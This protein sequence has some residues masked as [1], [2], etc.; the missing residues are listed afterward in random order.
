MIGLKRTKR[1][2][3][4]LVIDTYTDVDS[5][6]DIQDGFFDCIMI[7][8]KNERSLANILNGASPILSYKCSYKPVFATVIDDKDRAI[9]S[10]IDLYTNNYDT[11]KV[12][13][14][15]DKIKRATRK[16]HIKREIERPKSPNQLFSNICRYLLSRD[17]TVIE[18]RLVELSSSG[19]I[20][21]IVEHYHNMGM[22]HLSELF[23]FKDTM[24]ENGIFRIRKFHMKQHLCPHC[25]HSHLLYSECCPK[26]GKS[27]L[28][29]ENVI[30]HFSCA[31]V[32]PESSYNVGGVLVCPKCGKMLRH[33]GVDYDRPAVIYTCNVC[34]NS[35][36]TPLTKATCTFCENTVDVIKLIP[37]D[38][39]DLE[40]TEEGIRA[41]THGSVVFSN[42]VNYN[43]NYLEYS[44]FENRI[45]RLLQEN[46]VTDTYKVLIAKIWIL[47]KDRST[48]KIK[49]SIQS[50]LCQIF[51]NNKVS[52]N[53]N[54]FY[55]AHSL[56]DKEYDTQEVERTFR[57]NVSAGIRKI[58]NKI[59]QDEI[60]CCTCTQCEK[61]DGEN[62]EEFFDDLKLVAALPDDFC[63]YSENPEENTEKPDLEKFTTADLRIDKDERRTR[64]YNRIIYLLVVIAGVVFAAAL[65]TLAMFH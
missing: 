63:Q 39:V 30:H 32:A 5:T 29:I 57:E 17:T 49:D 11:D 54:I 1:G 47:N 3:K 8:A 60:V 42:F 48:Q 58:S 7:K 36:T 51:F 6:V 52:Y 13:E 62:Y 9:N 64:L 46:R 16:Y 61:K 25:N 40:I 26:C 50:N 27:D 12:Y 31:N 28:R 34:S 21:P 22:F 20:N 35:F 2:D 15:I 4:I 14:I 23:M 56:Y 24:I 18:H 65:V 55:V 19:Y 37:H 53:N 10:L 41:L 38:V 45:R 43:D 59:E 33:I 44:I